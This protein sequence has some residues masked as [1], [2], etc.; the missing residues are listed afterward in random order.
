GARQQAPRSRGT[1]RGPGRVRRFPR[2]REGGPLRPGPGHHPLTHPKN[3]PGR[4]PGDSSVAAPVSTQCDRPSSRPCDCTR[5]MR[6]TSS[7]STDDKLAQFWPKS[8]DVIAGP[9]PEIVICASQI[10]ESKGG[11]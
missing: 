3:P 5:T 11:G 8:P 4:H 10:K 1:R 7:G 9:E 6:G 2:G